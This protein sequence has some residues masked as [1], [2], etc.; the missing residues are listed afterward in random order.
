MIHKQKEM[1]VGGY[2]MTLYHLQV[3]RHQDTRMM[4]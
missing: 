4:R 3:I 2:L 1:G